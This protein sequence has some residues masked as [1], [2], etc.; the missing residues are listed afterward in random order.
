MASLATMTQGQIAFAFQVDVLSQSFRAPIS[1]E[2]V[3]NLRLH[4][5]PSPKETINSQLDKASRR[6]SPL[7][8][9]APLTPIP[10][11]RVRRRLESVGDNFRCEVR[12]HDREAFHKEQGSR[13]FRLR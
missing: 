3:L 2:D 13:T 1:S 12:A 4:L 8:R 5:D 7:Q 11:R 10:D 6:L 9:E